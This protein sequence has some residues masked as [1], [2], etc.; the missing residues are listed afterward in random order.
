MDDA[1]AVIYR[2]ILMHVRRDIVARRRSGQ[3]ASRFR[4]ERPALPLQAG[5]RRMAPLH[6]ARWLG[7]AAGTVDGDT[8]PPHVAL[9]LRA[10]G[11]RASQ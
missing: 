7:L 6:A 8:P 1:R 9:S 3:A 4:Y 10:R 5:A 11:C 2:A